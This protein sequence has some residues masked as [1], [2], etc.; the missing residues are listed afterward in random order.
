MGD[1]LSRWFA[2]SDVLNDVSDEREAQFDQWGDQSL[3]FGTGGDDMA[4]LARYYREVCQRNAAYGAVT[5]ADVL[6]EEVYEALS[7][8]D[9]VKLKDELVQVAAVAVQII[10]YINRQGGSDA[11]TE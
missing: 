4:F 8:A 11:A 1:H 10:E 3:P 5:W 2:T 7:E 9:P 6:L